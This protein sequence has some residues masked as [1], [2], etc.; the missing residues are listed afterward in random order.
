MRAILLALLC[1]LSLPISAQQTP[2]TVLASIEPV[3][4]LLREV[5]GEAVAVQ[6]LMLPNQNP[7]TVAFTPG[8]ARQLRSADLVVWLGADAEPALAGLVARH[9]ESQ[10]AMTALPEI[11]RHADA[12][13]DH[14]HDAPHHHHA[15]LDP[16]LWLHPGN[17]LRLAQVLP[18]HH[19]ALGVE[20]AW[21]VEQVNAFEAQLA[22][23][24]ATVR[25][26]LAPMADTPYLSHHDPWAY[27]AAEMGIR[28]PL[29]ISRSIEAS[30]S[31]RRFVEL[32]GVMRN[33]GVHCV[34]AEPEASRALLQRLCAGQCRLIEAD[35]LG[36]DV[37]GETY[38]HFLRHLGTLFSRCLAGG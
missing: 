15:L 22:D 16:H 5:L 29:V 3:A 37:A 20:H 8:Q 18:A 6:T 23:V 10:L 17:M 38:S 32:S 7:H 30:A 33:Q 34:L 35:P 13:H 9:A 36:R 19:Q 12:D 11:Y 14:D 4:M 26:Q 31:S 2:R 21:L 25:D 24:Q 28:R 27:F 1:C